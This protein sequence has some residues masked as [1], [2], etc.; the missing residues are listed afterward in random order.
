MI[1][2]PNSYIP[3]SPS[4]LG[5]QEQIKNP[6]SGLAA[7]I[8]PSWEKLV[9]ICNTAL[10]LAGIA[11]TFF[12]KLPMLSLGLGM[13]AIGYLVMNRLAERARAESTQRPIIVQDNASATKQITELQEEVKRK[14]ISYDKLKRAYEGVKKEKNA[15]QI[16][17][18]NR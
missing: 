13:H 11:Y 10:L 14:R 5:D 12:L 17:L 18:G 6:F 9:V 4:F 3:F 1:I 15:L 2:H 16:R 8:T 7:R